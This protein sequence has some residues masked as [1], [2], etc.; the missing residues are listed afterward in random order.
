L[1]TPAAWIGGRAHLANRPRFARLS[2][3]ALQAKI[4]GERRVPNARSPKVDAFVNDLVHSRKPE[5]EQLR[6]AIL[7]APINMTE[8]VKWN[9]PS[10][11]CDGDDRVTFRLQPRDRVELIFHRG[12]KKRADTA[13]FTFEDPT[14]RLK[15]LAPDRGVVVLADHNDTIDMTADI[16]ALVEAWMTSTRG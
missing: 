10:F 7:A 8:Q 5:I 6:D 11:C 15:W 12:A 9:A 13:T 16:V 4:S 2:N 3:E 14:G 1:A